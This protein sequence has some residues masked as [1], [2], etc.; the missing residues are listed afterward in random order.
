MQS[1]SLNLQDFL[2][3]MGSQSRNT[4][5]GYSVRLRRFETFV[6]VVFDVDLDKLIKKLQ[7]KEIDVYH[8]LSS[9]NLALSKENLSSITRIQLI[10]AAK[11]FL[12]YN[13]VDISDYKFRIKVRMPKSTK[14]QKEALDKADIQK[15][16]LGCSNMRLKTFVMLIAATGMRA[17]EGLSIRFKDVDFCSKPAQIHLQ[18][19]VT[20]TREGRTVYLTDEIV[21]QLKTFFEYRQRPRR[22]VKM[23]KNGKSFA[24]TVIPP[25]KPQDRI[26]AMRNQIKVNNN[27]ALYVHLVRQFELTLDRIGFSER[28][29]NNRRRKI[30][31][32]SFRRYVKSTISDLGYQDYSEWFIGHSGSTYYRKKDSEKAELFRKVEPYLT[33]LGYSELEARGADVVTKL[34]EK[35][36]QIEAL[37]KKQEQFEQLIQS[38]IDSGQLQPTINRTNKQ[39]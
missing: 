26:F 5:R 16:I 3:S 12:L 17:S 10:S 20:K 37:T 15:I 9:Y 18:A 27:T 7:N 6:N 19:E 2:L 24:A 32:H 8:V 38:L 1:S 14:Q 13:D 22:I 23:N 36:K 30:T 28:E 21:N 34:Q 25:I 4:L 39:V 35:D 31:L 29:D 11:N 33:F